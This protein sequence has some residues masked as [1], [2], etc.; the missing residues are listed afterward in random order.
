MAVLRLSKHGAC[1][2]NA[3]TAAAALFVV[4]KWEI[5]IC[6]LRGLAAVASL[7]LQKVEVFSER[8]AISQAV[9]TKFRTSDLFLQDPIFLV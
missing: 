4:A 6:K 5:F 7:L 1:L 3:A 9:T 8:D 2:Q